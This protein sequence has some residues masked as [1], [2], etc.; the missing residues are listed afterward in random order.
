MAAAA[1]KLRQLEEYIA[2]G[3]KAVQASLLAAEERYNKCVEL[4][5]Q[6]TE[7]VAKAHALKVAREPGLRLRFR[8]RL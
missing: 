1:V 3:S 2:K 4:S 5:A 6:A 8:T 7:K